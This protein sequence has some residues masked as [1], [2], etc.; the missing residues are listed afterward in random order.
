VIGQRLEHYEILDKL[1]E[2]GMGVVYKAR[3]VR[4]DRLR[5]S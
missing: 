1:G 4:L 2:G 5:V 3:D